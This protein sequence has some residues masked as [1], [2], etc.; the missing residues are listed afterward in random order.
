MSEKGNVFDA[1]FNRWHVII[2]PGYTYFPFDAEAL[3]NIDCSLLWWLFKTW[4]NGISYSITLYTPV[5]LF[6]LTT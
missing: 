5:L 1:D 3:H 2:F 6:S 4:M